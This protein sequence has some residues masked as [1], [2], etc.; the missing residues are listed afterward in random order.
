MGD[1]SAEDFPLD[2]VEITPADFVAPVPVPEFRSAWEALGNEGEVRAPVFDLVV[3]NSG[4]HV[5]VGSEGEG[6][7]ST[8]SF[9]AYH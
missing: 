9:V 2:P 5:C 8:F 6:R 4:C 1:A 7:T 3:F